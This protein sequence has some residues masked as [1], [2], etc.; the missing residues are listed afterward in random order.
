MYNNIKCISRLQWAPKVI[1]HRVPSAGVFPIYIIHNNIIIMYETHYIIYYSGQVMIA[2]K[3]KRVN[4]MYMR[5]TIMVFLYHGRRHRVYIGYIIITIR[6]SFNERI[7]L[8]HAQAHSI[9]II[10]VYIV[11]TVYT[12]R[13]LAQ[14]ND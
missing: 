5:T 7:C 9:I 6:Y 4:F 10:R 8:K 3:K 12:M 14:Y 13:Y 11:Y 1:R 2:I